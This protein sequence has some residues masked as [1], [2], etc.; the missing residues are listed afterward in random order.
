[1]ESGGT[2]W[3]VG[4]APISEAKRSRLE[5]RSI[6]YR[7][8]PNL[9]ALLDAI[10]SERCDLVLLDGLEG[11][12][13]VRAAI[14]ADEFLPV[15]IEA[16]DPSVRVRAL[17]AGADAA[18]DAALDVGEWIARVEAILRVRRT[19]CQL[20]ESKRELEKLSNTDD[21]TGLHNKRWLLARLSEEVRRAE[22]YQLGVALILMDMDH[23]KRIN[24]A[25]GH[26]FG[27]QV[28]VA[29]SDVLRQSF[30]SVD[31]VARFG[32]EEFAVVLPE[33]DL[34][35]A[36]DAAERFRI[37]VESSTFAGMALTISAGVAALERPGEGS[38][39]TLLRQADEALYLAKRAGRN[40]VVAADPRATARRVAP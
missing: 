9:A 36:V 13:P 8:A 39:E 26:L 10:G 17:E 22:R 28:L 7:Q 1:M 29:F 16:A 11:F 4:T 24:D 20:L 38:V 30:R 18:F 34:A 2:H 37:K 21:L 19:M 25:R 12:D 23:F 35:G 3:I 14:P 40:R 31:R 6:V 15:A 33:T 5:A 32:G 27:D